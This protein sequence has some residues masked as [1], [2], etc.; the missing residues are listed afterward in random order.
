[1]LGT[2]PS[3][4]EICA[5]V[6]KSFPDLK[7]IISDAVLSGNPQIKTYLFNQYEQALFLGY[8]AALVSDEKAVANNVKKI[9]FI[10]AQEYALLNKWIV[11]GFLEGARRADP[12]YGL[13]YRVIGNWYD[14]V[15]AADLAAAM[16]NAGVRVVGSIAGSAG[17]G[18]LKTAQERGG[19]TVSFNINEY[20]VAPGVIIGCGYIKQE[21]LTEQILGD[22]VAGG[23]E[24]GTAETLG[25]KDGYVEFLD[26]DPLY[27][28]QVSA[29]VRARMA[30]FV[31]GLKSGTIAYTLPAL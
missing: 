29:D 9:G 12:S 6:G 2:N 7:F 5:T 8:L 15:K 13:D 16:A 14:A 23:I 21:E 26:S 20:A 10:A 18:V 11:P 3:L 25:L 24:Y 17:Q 31:E 19:Y 1:V 28:Q 30:A 27:T 4:P 22:L